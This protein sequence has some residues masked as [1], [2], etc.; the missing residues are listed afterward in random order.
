MLWGVLA[1]W[2]VACLVA[3][4][5]ARSHLSDA[6]ADLRRAEN[7]VRDLDLEAALAATRDARGT[8]ASADEDLD[9]WFLTPLRA[10]PVVSRNLRLGRVL[11]DEASALTAAGEQLLVAVDDVVTLATER[12][13]GEGLPV[14]EVGRLAEPLTEL[15]DRAD[16]AAATVRRLDSGALLPPLRDAF[17]QFTTQSDTIGAQ[18]VT[19][20]DAAELAAALLGA[21]EPQRLFVGAVTPAELRGTGGVI[22]AWSVIEL[23]DGRFRFQPFNRI[24]DLVAESVGRGVDPPNPDFA[25]RWGP[26]DAMADWRN[27]N[28]TPDM[29]SAAVV[30]E[31]LWTEVR[32]DTPI[33][34]VLLLDPEAFAVLAR[35][36]GA[37][38]LSNG[39]RVP[40]DEIVD[41]V[42]NEAYVVLPDDRARREAIAEVATASLQQLV[43]QL[44]S[45]DVTATLS[46][47]GRLFGTGNTSLHAIDPELQATVERLGISGGLVDRFGDEIGLAFNNGAGNKVDFWLEQRWNV[48]VT[49]T[50]NGGS[51]T[52]VDL[53]VRNGAPTTGYTQEVLGPFLDDLGPGDTLLLSS[54]YCGVSCRFTASSDDLPVTDRERGFGVND[55]WREIPAGDTVNLRWEFVQD[56]SWSFADG[57]YRHDVHVDVPAT[58]RPADVVVTVQL[59][60]TVVPV[61]LPPEARLSGSAVAWR[62]GPGRSTL[63]IMSGERTSGPG[64]WDALRRPA[65]SLF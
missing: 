8:L 53:V 7:R 31:E 5:Q 6:Q 12:A 17:R 15:A 37:L 14:A 40:A 45:G 2:L 30:M 38:R 21:D 13:E 57:V 26:Y 59:P 9:R 36:A 10:V 54:L 35:S 44:G 11:V 33:D 4:V 49:P 16:E 58:V 28:M 52:T 46:R 19:G 39:R 51:R 27:T 1:G 23:D 3:G 50:T 20:A 43:D 25:D 60:A 18:A 41:F 62:P 32:P 64:V 47:L 56:E 34:G 29:P 42:T 22:G 55:Q 61:G 48:E 65:S 24:F 63:R